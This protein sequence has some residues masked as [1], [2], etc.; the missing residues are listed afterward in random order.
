[1]TSPR[2]NESRPGSAAA[3]V[4][5]QITERAAAVNKTIAFPFTP[6]IFLRAPYSPPRARAIDSPRRLPSLP[7]PRRIEFLKAEIHERGM[8]NAR[9]KIILMRIH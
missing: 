1:M 9:W 2:P 8:G 7:S 4:K 5:I 6:D 3:V